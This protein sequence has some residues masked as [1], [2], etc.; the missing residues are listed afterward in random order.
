[1]FNQKTA[2]FTANLTPKTL[3]NIVHLQSLR[4]ENQKREI[5]RLLAVNKRDAKRTS[6]LEA[7]KFLIK[8]LLK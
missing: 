3:Q 8:C 5:D 1:M 7:L 2:M 4:I 6:A